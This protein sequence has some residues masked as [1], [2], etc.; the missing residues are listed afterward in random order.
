MGEYN[1]LKVEYELQLNRKLDIKKMQEVSKLF[2]GIHNFKNFVSGERDNYDCII[3]S[4]DFAIKEELLEIKF[5]GKSFYR[6][7]VRNLVGAMLDVEKGKH[8][9][10]DIK[11]ALERYEIEKRFSTALPNGLYLN[12]IEYEE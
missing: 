8:T 4:I 10:E 3:Y 2:I 11:E 1:P 5:I 9:L 7:M 6:Y 12:K